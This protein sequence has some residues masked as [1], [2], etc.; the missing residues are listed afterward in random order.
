MTFSCPL[1][2]RRIACSTVLISLFGV[3]G[4][5]AAHAQLDDARPYVQAQESPGLVDTQ[6]VGASQELQ[7]L[8]ATTDDNP[9]VNAEP[10]ADGAT[11]PMN[12]SSAPATNEAAPTSPPAAD[13]KLT[14]D[15]AA[16]TDAPKPQDTSQTSTQQPPKPY[17][18]IYGFAQADVGYDF[19]S[20]D[21]DWFD[22]VRPTKLPS[23]P[24]EFGRNGNTYFSV[25]QTRFGVKGFHPTPWGDMKV[26]FEFDMFGVGV[27]A[28]QTTIRPRI[29]YGEIGAFGA[30]QTHSPFMDNDVFPNIFEYWG[31]N[32][33]VFF[34]N[35][36]V[37]WMP[38]RGETRLTLA[39]E[40]PGA[41]ADG[42]VVANRIEVQN[43][44][45]R[46]KWPDVSGEFRYGGKHGYIKTSAIVRNFK[47]DDQ[48][49]TDQFNLDQNITAWGVNVSSNVK[50]RKDVLRLQYVIGAGIQNYM[51]DAPVDVAPE[52][53]PGHPTRPIKGKALPLQS[54]VAFLDHA[55][56]EHFSSSI[57]YSQ[58]RISNSNLQNVNDFHLGRYAIVNII[59]NPFENFT[60]GAEL[61]WG[62]RT[63][64]RNTF[65]PH[66]FRIQFSF[67][68][69][70]NFRIGGKS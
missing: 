53:N 18:D 32:G 44:R 13:A 65:E 64:F 27:D 6:I 17:L 16:K 70:F 33:M 48:I 1:N 62:H 57:G 7:P 25:R 5:Q 58:L 31:P 30:G 50:V 15:D 21:P 42:G 14:S 67:R 37:R 63:N 8:S 43:V 23:V 54:W 34:R 28:G 35:V 19:K 24:G 10:A 56:G 61:Q 60:Y 26:T 29:Y 11:V 22:V 4:A 45:G 41:S 20:V 3:F 39:L 38:I 47:L 68:Y 36:Q 55:W 69:N 51:N 66:D 2:W 52:L 46:F 12:S 9:E 40:R 49:P 59:D